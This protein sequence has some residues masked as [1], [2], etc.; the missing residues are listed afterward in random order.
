M[1]IIQRGEVGAW[2]EICVC[3]GTLYS[4]AH[5]VGFKSPRSGKMLLGKGRGMGENWEKGG[6]CCRDLVTS[7]K[8]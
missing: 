2:L 3:V 4:V 7:P 1:L 5:F 6:Y 8:R